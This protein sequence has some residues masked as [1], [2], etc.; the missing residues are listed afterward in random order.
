MRFLRVVL[1]VF[2]LL[3]SGHAAGGIDSGQS[4][5]RLLGIKDGL[6]NQKIHAM[7]QDRDGYLWVATNDGLARFDGNHFRVYRHIPGDDSSLPGNAVLMVHVDTGNRVWASVEGFGLFRMNAERNGFKAVILRDGPKPVSD[8]WSITSDDDGSVWV[9]T[10]GSGL[11]RLDNSGDVKQFKPEPGSIGLPDENVL[12]LAVDTNG[13][14]WI[15]TSSGIVIW[16]KGKFQA[17]DNEQLI[18]KVV[19]NLFP[20]TKGGMWLATQAGLQHF[21]GDGKFE[22]PA[23]AGDLTD[24]RI[25][26]LLHDR[27]DMPLIVAAKGINR[28]NGGSVTRIFPDKTFLSA[29]QDRDGGFW[30]G[31]TEGLLSQPEA[32]RAFKTYNTRREAGVILNR[33]TTNFQ[34]LSDGSALLVDEGGFLDV[35]LPG[36]GEFQSIGLKIPEQP[37]LQLNAVH[38]DRLGRIWLGGRTQLLLLENPGHIPKSW[39]TQ[40]KQDSTLLGPAKHIVQTSDGLV[41]I[42]FYGGGIQA[43]DEQG[44]VIHN[45][46]IKSNQ[47]LQFPDTEALFIGPDGLL[48]LVGGEGVLRWKADSR[49]FEQVPGAPKERIYSAF[50]LPNG[51]LWF[52]R[53]GILES[54]QWNASTEQ[55]IK[56]LVLSGDDGL[57][58]VE[59]SGIGA[60]KKGILWLTTSRGLLRF[61]P[62]NGRVR[63]FGIHDGLISQEFDLQPP[64]IGADGQAFALS[65]AGLVSFR[66]DALE[67]N[68]VPLRLRLESASVRREEDEL[69]LDLSQ[70][71]VLQP[72]DRELSIEALLMDFEDESVHRYRS[73]LIGFDPDWVEMGSS[74]RRVFSRLADGKYRLEIIGSGKEGDWSEPVHMDIHVL[75][76]FWKSGW[77]ILMYILGIVLVLTTVFELYRRNMKRKQD[78]QLEQQQREFMKNSSEAK[79]LFLA[80]LGHEIRTPMTGVLGM[81]ELLM[82]AGLPE[83]P[84]S[85]VMA[86]QKA[87]QHLLRLMNDALD[88]S[89]IEA[90]QFELD[91]QPFTP[92]SL[93]NDVAELLSASAEKKGLKLEL[94]IESNLSERYLGDIGRIRQILLNLGSN[95]IKFTAQGKVVINAQRLWPKGLLLSVSDSGPGM[96]A[97]QQARIFQRFVQ[98]EGALTARQFGGSGLGLAISRDFALLMG[99]DILIK[100]EPGSG[101][102]FSVTLPLDEL[103]SD[104]GS[105]SELSENLEFQCLQSLH[106]LLVEDDEIIASALADLMS[107]SGHRVSIAGNALEALAATSGN[108]FDAVICDLDLPGMSGLELAGIWRGQG[109]QT[110]II[111]LTA[112]TLSETEQQ[113]IDAGMNTFLRKPVSGIQLQKAIEATVFS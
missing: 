99:G 83:K 20:D 92:S 91:I 95:A 21:T 87:G 17:F 84:R 2:V 19:I 22:T 6:P 16:H 54:F 62:R 34:I 53:I 57:P 46:T 3:A 103:T 97:E 98:A 60:D 81:T 58:A 51:I 14:L 41:W 82:S 9:G 23:W 69:S 65:K 86:I 105:D 55:L 96:D 74:G 104:I 59:I 8:I 47:G 70:A 44:H 102:I 5:Y 42:A 100:S 36:T 39:S 85:Q 61:D 101:S 110:P 29:F 111:A 45:I 13:R 12:S 113:C 88:I 30:F 43:R 71:I 38:R 10:F 63:T 79:T 106:I 40:S 25:M 93:L 75:P 77:A 67:A 4:Q 64:Y 35:F 27:N 33:Q 78:H 50:Q 94:V 49:K 31:S 56:K 90:G 48:W 73:R 18:S 11:F 15:A 89:K 66:P 80:N 1:T 37:L 68:A 107:A 72:G 76:P 108:C 52:G 109:M 32:W 7:D 28:A 26:G 112:R 24:P